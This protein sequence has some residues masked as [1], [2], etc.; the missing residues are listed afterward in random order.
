MCGRFCLYSSTDT[1]AQEIG[2]PIHCDLEP[3]H[4]IAPGDSILN[5]T[6]EGR[7]QKRSIHRS[8]W[9]LKTPQN[10]HIN[11]RIETV[12]TAPR[13]REAWENN[14]A[15]IPANGFYEWYQDGLR[16][17][18]YYIFPTDYKPLYFGALHYRISEE[19]ST[20]V[21]ITTSANAIIEPIH[22]RMPLLIPKEQHGAWLSGKLSKADAIQSSEQIALEAHTVSSRVNKLIHNDPSLIEKKDPIQ[23][24]QLRFFWIRLIAFSAKRLTQ[25]H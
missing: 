22:Q 23:D 12:D 13:F 21:L 15:L 6:L 25:T 11:S 4:N 7:E 18:P 9:G 3:S 24:D 17:Q 14:R 20:V 1:L 19:E 2:I 10:F 16:K 8:H 5:I